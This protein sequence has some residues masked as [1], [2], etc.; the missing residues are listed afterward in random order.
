MCVVMSSVRASRGAS[1]A[2]T[3]PATGTR[4]R[5][6]APRPRVVEMELSVEVELSGEPGRRGRATGDRVAGRSGPGW[7]FGAELGWTLVVNGS[8][9]PGH[10]WPF[11]APG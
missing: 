2:L 11:V 5:V 10:L 7:P 4:N 9:R 6:V 8:L 3:A 1:A